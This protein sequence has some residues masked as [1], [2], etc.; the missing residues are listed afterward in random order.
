MSKTSSK[1]KIKGVFSSQE[2]M[3][4][5]TGTTTRRTIQQSYWFAEEL[6]DGSIEIQPLNRNYVPSGSKKIIPIEDFLQKYSPEP[7]FYMSNVLPRMQELRATILK[8]EGHRKKNEL[9]TAEAEFSKAVKVDEE[10]V[11]ANFGLG[12]T[13]LS[14]GE[15]N[16]AQDIFERLVNLDG[17]YE[18]E[19][20][21]LFNEFGISLRKNKLYDQSLEYY[22][23]A[24]ALSKTDENLFYN[25]ARAYFDKGNYELCAH[26]LHKSLK[27]RQD[28]EEA[29]K[30]LNYLV[31]KGLQPETVLTESPIKKEEKPKVGQAEEQSVESQ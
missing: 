11:R 19:H 23:K 17:A 28:M 8:G 26:Y 3:K 12:L 22:Q 21:H 29:Q 13:Y 16:K 15:A 10:N 27:L 25:I 24:E 20:K 7:E 30:F 9:F 31:A 18:E 14:R 5:G 4:I 2:I 6:D 1:D